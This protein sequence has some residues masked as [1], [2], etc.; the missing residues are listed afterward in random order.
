MLYTNIVKKLNTLIIILIVLALATTGCF[1]YLISIIN[2][3]EEVREQTIVYEDNMSKIVFVD[4]ILPA[5]PIGYSL[6]ILKNNDQSVV[7]SSSDNSVC[8][9]DN[10]TVTMLKKGKATISA[11]IDD[12]SKTIDISVTD[13]YTLPDTNINKPF[14]KE[15]IC[16]E[17]EAHMLDEILKIKIENAGYKKRAGVVAAARFLGLEFPYKLTYFSESGRLDDTTGTNICDGEGRYYHEGLFLS[18]DKFNLLKSSVYGP[19]Y[20][21]QFFEEDDSDD[22]SLDDYYLYDGFVPADIGSHLYLSKRP[23]GLDCSGHVSWCYLNGGFDL[24]D[25]GAGGPDTYGMAQLGELAYITDDLLQSNRI[26]AGD[27]VGYPGHVGI[28][29][30]IEDDYIWICDTLVTGMKVTKYEKNKSSFDELGEDAWKYFM[31]MDNV[32]IEDGNYTP[33]W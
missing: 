30:G 21:G 2:K 28:V 14:L 23:N 25:M 5:Y 32:Y 13:L 24:G 1:Y 12:A 4:D 31:L 9:I 16:D 20:W 6:N 10:Y 19:A 17:Q 27:L 29:I 8:K 26:K 11:S 33:M 7:L 22:H 3:E 15:T 18:E